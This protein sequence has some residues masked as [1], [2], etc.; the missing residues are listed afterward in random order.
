ML[1]Y[2]DVLGSTQRHLVPDCIP[3]SHN[4][5]IQSAVVHSGGHG[6]AALDPVVRSGRRVKVSSAEAMAQNLTGLQLDQ[7][8]WSACPGCWEL[9]GRQ[10]RTISGRDVAARF[11]KMGSLC[12]IH[13]I[14]RPVLLAWRGVG[15]GC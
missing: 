13:C 10:Q 7:A 9:V 1:W 12:Q 8:A 4:K 15:L 5:E 6:F 11:Y 3:C 14:S 2:T